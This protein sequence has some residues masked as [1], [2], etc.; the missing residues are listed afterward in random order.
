MKIPK[1]IKP[2][3]A[4]KKRD[5]AKKNRDSSKFEPKIRTVPLKAGQLEIMGESH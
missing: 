4:V 3:N 1:F 2:K 5:K